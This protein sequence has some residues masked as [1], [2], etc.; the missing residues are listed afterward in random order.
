MAFEFDQQPPLSA[1]LIK[2]P[3]YGGEQRIVDLSAVDLWQALKQNLRLIA[4]EC[5]RYALPR[6]LCVE[7]AGEINWQRVN[8]PP[9]VGQPIVYFALKLAR[10][11]IVRQK[12]GPT[13][14]G[15]RLA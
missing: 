13:P 10:I 8:L 14:I 1:P 2:G 5:N 11:G 4:I 3:R 12:L 7:S 9:R 15:S 6:S